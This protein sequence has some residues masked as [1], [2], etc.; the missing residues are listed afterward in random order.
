MASMTKIIAEADQ[1][2]HKEATIN[3][4]NRRSFAYKGTRIPRKPGRKT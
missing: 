3:R 1:I 4:R 2:R